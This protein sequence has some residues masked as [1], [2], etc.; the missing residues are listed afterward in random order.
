MVFPSPKPSDLSSQIPG[1]SDIIAGPPEPLVGPPDPNATPSGEPAL[2]LPDDVLGSIDN[3]AKGLE[4]ENAA[5][6]EDILSRKEAGGQLN[7][8]DTLRSRHC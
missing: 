1:Q 8:R 4:A 3:F 7:A 6:L 2:E 5:E